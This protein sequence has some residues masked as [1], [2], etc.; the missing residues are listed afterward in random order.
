M[1]AEKWRIIE[2]AADCAFSNKTCRFSFQSVHHAVF[3]LCQAKLGEALLEGLQ[4]L[5][6]LQ[7]KRLSQ[8]LKSTDGAFLLGEFVVLWEDYSV[9]LQRIGGLLLYFKNFLVATHRPSVKEIGE[10]VFCNHILK[11]ADIEQRLSRSVQESVSDSSKWDVLREYSKILLYVDRGAFFPALEGVYLEVIG[12]QCNEEGRQQS[13]TGSV[14]DYLVW[15]EKTLAHQEEQAAD[16]LSPS[17]KMRLRQHI[18]ETLIGAGEFYLLFSET[19]CVAMLHQWNFRGI[20][21]VVEAFDKR[22]NPA[23]VVSVLTAEVKKIA[24]GTLGGHGDNNGISQSSTDEVVEETLRL[25]KNCETLSSL[26]PRARSSAVETSPVLKALYDAIN[27]TARF[28][29]KLSLYYDVHIRHADNVSVRQLSSDVLSLFRILR[30]RDGFEISYRNLLAARIMHA[31]PE[32]LEI[33]NH[34][35]EQMREECGPAAVSRLEKMI[36]DVKDASSMQERLKATLASSNYVLPL[37]FK[38]SVLTAGFWPQYS[39][40]TFVLPESMCTCA[41]VFQQF[42][43]SRHSGRKLSFQLS[44]GTVGFSLRHAGRL[45]AVSAPTPFVCVLNSLNTDAEISV[46]HVS[47]SSGL[48]KSDVLAQVTTLAKHG[49][50]VTPATTQVSPKAGS[51]S[52]CFNQHFSSQALKIRI[53]AG[54]HK[55]TKETNVHSSGKTSLKT[56]HI[57]GLESAIVKVLKAN[58]TVDHDT[59]RQ[60]VEEILRPVF[61]PTRTEIKDRIDALI[62]KGFLTRGNRS[63]LYV[64]S[65]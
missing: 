40:L 51:G 54:P 52:Y 21:R 60:S 18:L 4:N 6:S 26:L 16:L 38:V 22:G 43:S 10:H 55:I 19:G 34:F 11:D 63:G 65:S 47:E 25:L 13:R 14:E 33:E 23:G 27:N 50:V 57:M 61:T 5:F 3:Q 31:K 28:P 58:K 64:Y 56:A 15:V 53:G 24:T 62:E 20:R 39:A 42:Y 12:A 30:D 48:A 44:L 35:I 9:A 36:A 29:D 17:S 1:F 2:E 37:E 59:L 8:S 46:D 32:T 49:L 41:G 45:H 7:V